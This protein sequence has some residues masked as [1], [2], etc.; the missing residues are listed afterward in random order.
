MTLNKIHYKKPRGGNQI[1]EL[2]ALFRDPTIT[3]DLLCRE[4]SG[5]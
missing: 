2:R 1:I 5:D 4:V 3:R